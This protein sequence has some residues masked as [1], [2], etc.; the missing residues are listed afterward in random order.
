MPHSYAET[1]TLTCANCGRDFDPQFWL[2][3]DVVERPDLLAHIRADDLH[4]AQCPHCAAPGHMDAPLLLFNP[5][6]GASQASAGA[7]PLAAGAGFPTVPLLFSPAEQTTA[8]ETLEQARQLLEMLQTSLGDQWQDDWLASGLPVV[9]REHLS[10]ALNGNTQVDPQL[11]GPMAVLADAG[12]LGQ[13]LLA[14]LNAGNMDNGRQVIEHHPE[15]LTEEADALIQRLLAVEERPQARQL[16]DAWRGL[17]ARCRVVGINQAFEEYRTSDGNMDVPPQFRADLQQA[18]E[19]E[20]HYLRTGDR[21][22][23]NAA[24][25]AWERILGH[26]TFPSSDERFQLAVMNDAGGVF[27][28]RYWATGGLADLNRALELGQTAVQRTPPDSPDLPGYLNNLANGLSDRYA[29][30]GALQDLQDAQKTYARACRGGQIAHP[31]TT[32]LSSRSWGNWALER[33]QWQEATEAYA[34]G[35]QAMD[36]LF[37]VQTNRAAKESWL[38]EAQGLPANAAY[39]LTRLDRL[40]E[41]VETLEAGRARLLAEALEANRRDLAQLALLGRRDLL[42]RYRAASEQLATLQ[43]AGRQPASSPDGPALRPDFAALRR[44]MEAAR[45]DLDAAIAAIRQVDGYQDFFLPPSFAQIQQAATPDAPLVYL[46]ATSAGGLALTATAPSQKPN[47]AEKLDFSAH[48][49]ALWLDDLTEAALHEILAGSADAAALGGYLGAYA[50]WRRNPDDAAS[51]AWRAALDATTRWLWDAA[52]Q[53]VVEHLAAQGATQ[54]VLLPAGLLGLLPLHAAWTEDASA[55]TGRRYALDA[56]T[57]SYAPSAG[58]LRHSLAGAAAPADGL[59]AVDNPDGSLVFSRQE[60]AAVRSY[61]PPER[62]TVLAGAGAT[63]QA[64]LRR[65]AALPAS[66]FSTHGWAGWDDPLQGGLLLANGA[67]LTLA[68]ILDLR[69]EGARLAVLS[70]CETGV[71]GTKLP[72]EVVSLPTGLVQAGVAG[73]VASLWAVNDRST[74]ML[75]ERFYRLWR[76]DGLAPAEA[77]R[78]AQIWLRDSSN[79]EMVAYFEQ[80]VPALAGYRMPEGVAAELYVERMLQLDGNARSFAHPFYWAAFTMTGA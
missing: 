63:R 79:S 53:P 32:M 10:A 76:E 15:L 52:M 35:R 20:Q 37:A 49:A 9:P 62:S 43:A 25:A 23:L 48:V 59:L 7:D 46:L 67:A 69:L 31:E 72:D 17:L 36:L 41:A 57:I 28:R 58:A 66:H 27:L 38:K 68:D 34:F 80:D 29:R 56:L 71:P 19:A 54:A 42:E 14:L 8:D 47:F 70:A 21:S 45:G 18:K 30:T 64:V 33:R 12:D 22:A 1:L 2:I 16:V 6:A 5:S 74:A 39:A 26:S 55:P 3:V 24:A 11:Q 73:V 61:F 51:D 77:L 78:R 50:R 65:L 13:H 75:M 4:D 44:Q 40:Q 60:V